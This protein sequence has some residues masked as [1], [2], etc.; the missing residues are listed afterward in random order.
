MSSSL[1]P[2]DVTSGATKPRLFDVRNIKPYIWTLHGYFCSML[3]ASEDF[4]PSS[5]SETSIIT[6]NERL[7]KIARSGGTEEQR[8]HSSQSVIGRAVIIDAAVLSN[9]MFTSAN[10]RVNA[11][12]ETRLVLD[13]TESEVIGDTR[14]RRRWFR[15]AS[16]R[17]IPTSGIPTMFP[18]PA[19]SSLI[20]F[21]MLRR[22][23]YFTATYIGYI[24]IYIYRTRGLVAGRLF[25]AYAAELSRGHQQIKQW[26]VSFSVHL[27]AYNVRL[28]G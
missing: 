14:F 18:F 10:W 4:V 15:T 7:V 23:F 22:V 3:L 12:C 20:G 1:W 8:L 27:A 28:E 25:V 26:T 17:G 13:N 9:K 6:K 24:Y 16:N 5:T 21:E 19:G 11:S 2:C